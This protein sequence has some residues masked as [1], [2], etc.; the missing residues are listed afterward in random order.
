M[1]PAVTT[2]VTI[3]FPNGGYRSYVF[4]DACFAYYVDEQNDAF[5]EDMNNKFMT[6]VDKAITRYNAVDKL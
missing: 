2:I 1:T 6:D 3:R 4:F 5:K